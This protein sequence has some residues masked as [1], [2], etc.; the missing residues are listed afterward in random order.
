VEHCYCL[1]GRAFYRI[2]AALLGSEVSLELS[3]LTNFANWRLLM[4]LLGRGG[5]GDSSMLIFRLIGRVVWKLWAFEVFVVEVVVGSCLA[6]LD[7]FQTV[8]C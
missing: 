8:G 1:L 4:A 7:D 3:R 6:T 5:G 2:L